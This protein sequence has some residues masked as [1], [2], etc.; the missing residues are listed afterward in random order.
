MTAIDWLFQRMEDYAER[1]A[2]IA[3]GAVVRYDEL[4]A[5]CERWRNRLEEWQIRPGEAVWLEGDYEL[6]VC[7]A[8]LALIANRNIAVPATKAS[9]FRAPLLQEMA[10]VSVILQ[11]RNGEW[12]AERRDAAQQFS[13]KLLNGIAASGKPGLV[14]FSSGSTGEPKGIVHDL[15]KLLERYRT[16]RAA[17]RTVSFLLF[18]HI[19]GLN[20]L[21]HTLSNGGSVIVPAS[22]KPD[23]VC[24]VVERYRAELLP[25]SP[26]FLHLLLLSDIRSRYDLSSLKVI[27][28]GTEVMPASTLESLNRLL[29]DVQYRQTYGLSEL[30]I[31]RAKSESSDSLWM[32]IGG[33][34]METRIVDGVLHIRSDTAMEGYLNAPNP[35]D[36]EG[37]FNTQDRVEIKGE[38]V[39]ILGRQSELINVGGQKVFPA[40]IESVLLLMPQIEDAA[41]VGRA[42][43]LLGQVPEAIVN[44]RNG[45]STDPMTIKNLIRN[46]CR[47]K[48]APFQIPVYVTIQIEPLLTE[49][50]KK[51]RK[52]ASSVSKD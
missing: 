5:N 2:L 7:G 22:R 33:E 47:D 49:R 31:M 45:E 35:F 8:L 28:Y 18:D 34:G 37:W 30:G 32:R 17:F 44:V 38:L 27:T 9:A 52:S 19:G 24:S 20:T 10:G 50:F 14:L 36:E 21:L 29:P 4:S 39:R 1:E 48:L 12:E 16:P 51:I 46:H 13:H 42:H 26:S 3:D 25:A 11:K 43:P 23:D 40:E 15:S 41:V 6:N